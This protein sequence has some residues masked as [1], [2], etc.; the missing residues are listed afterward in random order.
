MTVIPPSNPEEKPVNPPVT[1][2]IIPQDPPPKEEPKDIPRKKTPDDVFEYLKT[3]IRETI[4]YALLVL[5][6]L[7]IYF[8]P[9][10][11]GTLVGLVGGI[12]FGDEILAA[13]R[14]WQDFIEKEGISRSLV[15]GGVIFALF[16]SAPAIFI[17]A[18][19]ALVIKQFFNP[20]KAL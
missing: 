11:G 15:I 20:D 19:I 16:L 8:E 14:G 6:I 5:G 13:I 18:A 4:A 7:L 3:N 1:P 12:Y 2:P 9:L 17:G 10:Y